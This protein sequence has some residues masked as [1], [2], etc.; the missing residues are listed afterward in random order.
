MSDITCPKCGEENEI[1][2]DDGYGYE[3][4][5]LHEQHCD[6]C[7][8]EFKFTT[9]MV[10]YYDVYCREGDHDMEESHISGFY[11]CNKCEE[12]ERR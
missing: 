2:H 10:F 8:Y 6:S 1:N 3:E 5:Q 7:H 11:M 12:V 9:S 4:E